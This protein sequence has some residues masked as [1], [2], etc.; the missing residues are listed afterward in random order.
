MTKQQQGFTLMEL[1][2]VV[3]IVAI[4]AAIAVPAYHDYMV[5]AR[6]TELI[7]IGANA[8]TAVSEY[9][10][11]KRAMPTS[12]AQVGLTSVKTQ[13]AESVTIGTGGIITIVGNETSIGSKEPISITLT[14]ADENGMIKWTCS[15]KGATQYLPAV[16][17]HDQ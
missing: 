1:M 3:A 2:I 17:R 11:S 9:Y 5:R 8:K 4:L 12:N 16:C 14:P 7:S 13:Y 6:V 10:L 15:G